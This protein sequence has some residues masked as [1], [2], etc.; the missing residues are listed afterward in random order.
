V[1]AGGLGVG[2]VGGAQH[3]DEELDRA[4]LAGGGIGQP[5]LLAGVV[6]EALV[7]GAVDLAHRQAPP[8]Q[9]A[10]VQVAEPGVAIAVGLALQVLQVQQLQGDARLAPLGMNPGAVRGGP[11][12]LPDHL[13][14]AIEP[15]LEPASGSVWT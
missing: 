9:P 15:A 1:G 3:G 6:D 5:G 10:A 7:A 11:L 2:V 12:P 13:R 4:D 14:P 8:L